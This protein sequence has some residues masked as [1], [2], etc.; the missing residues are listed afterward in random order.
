[1]ASQRWLSTVWMVTYR[2]GL[3][4][5]EHYGVFATLDEALR[6]VMKLPATFVLPPTVRDGVELHHYLSPHVTKLVPPSPHYLDFDGDDGIQLRWCGSW[7]CAWRT[8]MPKRIQTGCDVWMSRRTDPGKDYSCVDVRVWPENLVRFLTAYTLP[9]ED[10]PAFQT[11]GDMCQYLEAR[12]YFI[13]L[14]QG[15]AATNPFE[16]LIQLRWNRPAASLNMWHHCKFQRLTVVGDSRWEVQDAV[17]DA[18]VQSQALPV[19]D[20]PEIIASFV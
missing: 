8:K 2:V 6:C 18:L 5:A 1:M 10:L 16:G 9:N 3:P 12:G 4:S 7:M 20:L 13:E 17:V 14:A 19:A 15:I 11:I